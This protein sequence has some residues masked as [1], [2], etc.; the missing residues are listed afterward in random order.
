MLSLV[1]DKEGQDCSQN[2]SHMATDK[3]YIVTPRQFKIWLSDMKFLLR[4]LGTSCIF[5]SRFLV[6]RFIHADVNFS[7]PRAI[8]TG[9]FIYLYQQ[10]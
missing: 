2:R 5:L 4:N 6:P 7:Y 9:P 1:L 10:I 8:V 3:V